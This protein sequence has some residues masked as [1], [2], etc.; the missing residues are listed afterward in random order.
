MVKADESVQHATTR[1][2]QIVEAVVDEL[3]RTAKRG[4]DLYKVAPWIS[5]ENKRII[6][7]ETLEAD[8]V[9][10]L[11]VQTLLVGSDEVGPLTDFKC[12]VMAE[13]LMEASGGGSQDDRNARAGELLTMAGR[14][15]TAGPLLAYEL[16]YRD[17]AET[18]LLDG[19]R[20][21]LDW[22]MRAVAHNSRFH[23]SDDLPFQL[24]DI[25]SAHLQLGDLDEGLR[26]LAHLI[27]QDPANQWTY[28]FM[29]TGFGV[30]GLADLGLKGTRRGLQLLDEVGDPEDLH[31]E[32]LMA[33]FDV[34]ASVKRGREAEVSSDV[35]AEMEAAL[36]LDFSASGE[37]PAGLPLD[38]PVPGL[39]EVPVKRPMRFTDVPEVLRDRME[40]ARR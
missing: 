37:R 6:V 29:A 34:R 26:L 30:L 27:R 24:I 32:F 8:R 23:K 39:D 35:M 19:D 22:L 10:A 40:R 28:R 21:A 16:L 18:A 4:G 33:E 11:S 36:A 9:E 13:R 20:S 3:Q 25:A 7:A 5:H 38:V 17:L 14:S 15:P 1:Y 31:D 12:A 2:Q